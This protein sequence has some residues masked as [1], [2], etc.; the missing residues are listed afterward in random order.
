MLEEIPAQVQL[1]D[2]RTDLPDPPLSLLGSSNSQSIHDNN[3]QLMELSQLLS[4]LVKPYLF[5]DLSRNFNLA[6]YN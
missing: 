2:L 5:D 6:L 3:L 1:Y 4:D